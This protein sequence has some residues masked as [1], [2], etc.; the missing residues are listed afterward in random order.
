MRTDPALPPQGYRLRTGP[1]GVTV[2]HRDALGLRYALGALDQ[3]RA[4]HDYTATGYDISDHPDFPVR[5]FLLD[6]SRD[7]VPTR[8]TLARWIENRTWRSSRTQALRTG[9]RGS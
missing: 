8:R 1:G 2:D 7:R 5:G 9:G 3:L 6:I 4:G